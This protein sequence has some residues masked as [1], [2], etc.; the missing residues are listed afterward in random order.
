MPSA[1]PITR[2]S[3]GAARDR[4][5]VQR[6]C[7]TWSHLVARVSAGEYESDTASPG[8]TRDGSIKIARMQASRG[9]EQRYGEVLS[10]LEGIEGIE[11]SRPISYRR[12]PLGI[13]HSEPLSN[14]AMQGNV[15][16]GDCVHP[17]ATNTYPDS[18]RLV[19]PGDAARREPLPRKRPSAIHMCLSRPDVLVRPP[20]HRLAGNRRQN[21]GGWCGAVGHPA[22]SRAEPHIRSLR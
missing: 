1:P 21:A 15:F 10:W 19:E 8:L 7:F 11:I 16:Q 6:A 3:A 18:G 17:V 20:S 2:A 9:V 5:A 14:T 13:T 22:T 4:R 12:F